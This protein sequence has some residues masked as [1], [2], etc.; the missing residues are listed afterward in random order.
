MNP[1]ALGI[2]R[3]GPDCRRLRPALLQLIEDPSGTS[4]TAAARAHLE[5]CERC[6]A[7]VAE[8][9]LAGIAVHRSLAP[10]RESRPAADAWPRLRT[11]V[12]RRSA[13]PGRAASGV[14]G[15]ALSAGLAMA[16]LVP[17]GLPLA[18]GH[19][20]HEAGIDPAAIRAAGYRDAE[21]EARHL[22]AIILAGKE[23]SS[24]DDNGRAR[25]DLIRDEMAPVPDWH[26]PSRS[27]RIA[28]V[29]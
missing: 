4:L 8:V 29:R 16:M 6:H 22:R 12:T 28:S 24:D 20:V 14:H 1:T 17:L 13:S 23:A 9:V 15:I 11:R 26:A 5:R 10:A 3:G 21:D 7:D 2:V 19:V 25:V 18:R 27:P